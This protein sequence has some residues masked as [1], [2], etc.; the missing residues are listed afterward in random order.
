MNPTIDPAQRSK[1]A[2]IIAMLG[3]ALAAGIVITSLTPDPK[4]VEV[5]IGV[6]FGINLLLLLLGFR[7]LHIDSRQLDIRRPLWLNIGIILL[8]AVFV[9]YYLY[10]TRPEGARLTAILM[11]FGLV[12]AI[13]FASAI[14]TVLVTAMQ[15]GGMP[16]STF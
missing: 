3:V 8:A 16:S 7:W 1:N 15:P 2:I 11:F 4:V 6:Q 5:P 9:P 13:A 12:V 14:G 10:K